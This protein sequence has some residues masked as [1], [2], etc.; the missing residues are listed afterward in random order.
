[1]V[2]P[3]LESI[4]KSSPQMKAEHEMVRDRLEKQS[5]VE[6]QAHQKLSLR[7]RVAECKEPSPS[8]TLD[9]VRLV[10][11]HFGFLSADLLHRSAESPPS[12]V[13]V[14]H[15]NPEFKANLNSLDLISTRT[16]DTVFV[17]YVRKGR[18]DPQEILNSVTSKHYV[19]QAFLDF[20]TNLGLIIDVKSHSGWTGN[21]SSAWKAQEDIASPSAEDF[22]ESH[23]DHGGSAYDGLSKLVYWADV[24]HEIA[25]I[26]PSGRLSD[27]DTFSVES[28]VVKLRPVT[29]VEGETDGRSLS[30]DEGASISSH[31]YSDSSRNSWRNKSKQ[32]S[33]MTS[34]GC[35]TKVLVFWLESI[36]DQYSLPI[37]ESSHLLSAIFLNY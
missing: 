34:V 8:T 15:A 23:R 27:E 2:V 13:A 24:S 7:S 11:S 21:V 16:S 3:T 14:D 33:L 6:K 29:R 5:V 17:F 28:E 36:D 18:V 19:S 9:P 37:G 35:D 4:V 32:L 22:G 20:L 31:S 1:M 26:V 10:L 25:F 12:L 30:S